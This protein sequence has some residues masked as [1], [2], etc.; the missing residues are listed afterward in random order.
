MAGKSY[1]VQ[2]WLLNEDTPTWESRLPSSRR[3]VSDA[4]RNERSNQWPSGQWLGTFGGDIASDAHRAT[5]CVE[6]E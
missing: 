4:S 2:R 1:N 3:Q 6:V 5:H